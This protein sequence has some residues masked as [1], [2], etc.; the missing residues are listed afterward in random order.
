MWNLYN[1]IELLCKEKQMN[2]TQMCRDL[3]MPRSIMSELKAGR[4]VRLSAENSSKLSKYFDV[5]VDYFFNNAPFDVWEKINDDRAAFF[6]HIHVPKNVLQNVWGIDK[7]NPNSAKIGDVI[8]FLSSCIKSAY[9]D[10]GGNWF[11]DILP[12]YETLWHTAIVQQSN[13]DISND[14]LDRKEKA[15][16]AG[17]SR[18]QK[19]EIIFNLFSGLSAKNTELAL[20]GLKYL[21]TIP[22][23]KLPEAVRYLQ[24]LANSA[25]N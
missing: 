1:R 6:Y 4:T 14:E 2:I 8:R 10:C 16:E 20:K 25:E 11:I 5:S 19:Y 21:V 13:S 3:E 24:F 23:D 7:D 15:P 18:E 9:V 17:A 22:D 12:E